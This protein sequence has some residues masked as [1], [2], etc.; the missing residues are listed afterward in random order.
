MKKSSK[1]AAKAPAPKTAKKEFKPATYERAR[2]S[3]F[4]MK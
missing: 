3:V 4:G 1:P 2:K